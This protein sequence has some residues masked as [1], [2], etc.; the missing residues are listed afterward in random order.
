MDNLPTSITPVL[1]TTAEA[2]RYLGYSTAW[3]EL[4][5]AAG[6]GPKHVRL[7]AGYR[8]RQCDLDEWIA[9]RIVDPSAKSAKSAAKRR[10]KR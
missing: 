2:A 10:T 9:S 6:D 8:Y 7:G 5:R 4:R 1:F 3:L